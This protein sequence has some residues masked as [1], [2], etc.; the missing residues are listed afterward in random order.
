MRMTQLLVVQFLHVHRTDEERKIRMTFFSSGWVFTTY[1]TEQVRV[2]DDFVVVRI[3][4]ASSAASAS[5]ARLRLNTAS[6][7]SAP[8]EKASASAGVSDQVGGLH[9]VDR[10]VAASVVVL[11]VHVVHVVASGLR[12]ARPRRSGDD[13]SYRRPSDVARWRARRTGSRTTLVGVPAPAWSKPAIVE[14]RTSGHAHVPCASRR[15]PRAGAARPARVSHY[16]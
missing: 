8:S 7:A 12:P 15:A 11:V 1:S 14:A 5:A 9:R 2:V 6:T 13:R 16:D 3:F 10:F 4:F